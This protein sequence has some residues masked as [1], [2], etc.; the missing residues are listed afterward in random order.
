M[1]VTSDLYKVLVSNLVYILLGS[2]TFRHQYTWPWPCGSQMT[3]LE[4]NTSR[5]VLFVF[6]CIVLLSLLSS[7]HCNFSFISWLFM[8][9]RAA[10]FELQ[11]KHRTVCI[12]VGKEHNSG[13]CVCFM[14]DRQLICLKWCS[15]LPVILVI[16]T[17]VIITQSH[18]CI[19]HMT[20]QY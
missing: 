7:S 6:C 15:H 17:L 10:I 16:I 5:F 12:S 1:P 13:Y 18:I 4:T 9:E 20:N 8:S 11:F 3:K 19:L 2:G 14:G